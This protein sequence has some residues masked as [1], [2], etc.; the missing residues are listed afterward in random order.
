MCCDP[1][2]AVGLD[3]ITF[4]HIFMVGVVQTKGYVSKWVPVLEIDRS[5]FAT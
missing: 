2:W 1:R 3:Q 4:R 5:A